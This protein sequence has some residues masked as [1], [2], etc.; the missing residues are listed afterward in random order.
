MGDRN[1]TRSRPSIDASVYRLAYLGIARQVTGYRVHTSRS[2]LKNPTN[3]L[4]RRRGANRAYKPVE[5]N[6]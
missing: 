1:M 2:K 4:K 5:P 3:G 6:K